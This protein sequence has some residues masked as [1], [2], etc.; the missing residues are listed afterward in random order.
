MHDNSILNLL[1][2]IRFYGR[3]IALGLL[4]I[5]AIFIW[6]KFK[7]ITLF[8]EPKTE[9]IHNMVLEEIT[10]LGKLE[11]AKYSYKDV[12]E[13]KITQDFLPDPKAILIIHGEAIGCIDLSK[14]KAENIVSKG[15][16]LVIN[17]PDPEICNH[18]IDH[19]KSHIYHTEYAFMNEKLLL[20]EAYKKAEQQVF[21]TAL[22]SD[23]LEQTKKN[24]ELILK[25]L[26]ENTSGKKVAFRYKLRA[27]LP[28]LK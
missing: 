15:D 2:M 11:L 24:A 1:I 5:L 20:E 28:R 17:M 12:V 9:T 8:G 3:I 26:I 4:I 7:G 10:T 25:P 21:E 19:S 18:K 23:I 6:E 16:T 13:Q 14:I 27:T 22:S